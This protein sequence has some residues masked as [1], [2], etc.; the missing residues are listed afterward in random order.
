MR[1][2]AGCYPMG[3]RADKS[4]TGR[5][6][7]GKLM[8]KDH[9]ESRADWPL[10][11]NGAVNLFWRKSVFQDARS[12]LSDLGYEIAEIEYQTPETFR[13]ALSE[14]LKWKEQFGYE[15]WG[16][17]LDALADGV[18]GFPFP[19]SKS[20]A[21]CIENYDLFAKDQPEIAL[22]VLDIVEA[23]SRNHLLVGCRLIA[24]IQ[25][26]DASLEFG[27]L[28]CRSATWNRREWL[29]KDRGLA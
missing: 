18:G 5:A 15:P 12:Q 23:Q 27:P 10:L 25:T 2:R 21:I 22:A 6:F 19:Q 24:L 7:Q 29:W 3:C 28:G 9:D 1:F 26:N 8:F 11:Q 20:A 4:E 17:G 13:S 16:G 14:A